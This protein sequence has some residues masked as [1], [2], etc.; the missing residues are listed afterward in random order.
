MSATFQLRNALFVIDD[1]AVFIRRE[2]PYAVPWPHFSTTVRE[3]D[4]GPGGHGVVEP[5]TAAPTD[6][7]D[8]SGRH[9]GTAG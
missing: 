1:Q 5:D 9:P 8:T 3:D 7:G 2:A 4:A 6:A